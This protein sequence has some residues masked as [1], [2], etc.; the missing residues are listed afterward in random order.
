MR[1]LRSAALAF[2]L[3][4]GALPATSVA[5]QA[6]VGISVTIAPPALPVY[7]QPPIPGPGYH[8][9]PG[10]WAWDE[11]GRRLL[12]GARLLVAPAARRP[13]LDPRLVGL[14]RRRLRLP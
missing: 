11:G 4:L 12:L 1:A 2:A 8:W 7:V 9:I 5:P 13:A 3:A 6:A 10:Y 14:E